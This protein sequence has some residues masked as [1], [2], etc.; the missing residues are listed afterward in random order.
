MA[1]FRQLDEARLAELDEAALIEYLLDA[2][3]AGDKDQADL[4]LKIF[5]FGME[6]ALRGFVRSRLNSHGDA[7]IEEVAERALEDAIQS[8][9]T[10]RGSTREE[11]RGFVFKI[12]RFR[13]A[14]FLRKGRLSTTSIDDDDRPD[15]PHQ[16]ER[17]SVGD[18][19]NV[20]DTTLVLDQ[21]LA[22]LREDHRAVVELFVLSGYSAREAADLVRSRVDGRFND[23]MSEQNVHQ[24]ASRFRKDLRARLE[25]GGEAVTQ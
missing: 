11:A 12:A 10:L 16:Q 3:A 19:W 18:E 20:V 4:A 7:V 14:D 8:I 9:P 22:E 15:S 25:E 17:L 1:A 24:I 2:R 13:I 6:D 5:A 21:L 23:S